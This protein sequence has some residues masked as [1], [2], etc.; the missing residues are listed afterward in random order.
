MPGTVVFE[1]TKQHLDLYMG[2]HADSAPKTRNERRAVIKMLLKWCVGQDYLPPAH[3]LFE[4]T[5]LA[6]ENAEPEEI[7]VY[8]ADEFS[9]LLIRASKQPRMAK[10]GEEAERD[11]RHLLPVLALGGLAGLR[12]KETLRLA[13]EDIFHKSGCIEVKAFKSKTR[14]R[15][16]IEICPALV[17]WLQP[18]RKS[19]G[20]IWQKSYDMLHLDFGDLRQELGIENRR[21]GLRHSFISAHFAK[22]SD[23]GY[24]GQQGGTSPSMIHKHYKGLMTKPEGE[25]WFAVAPV[26][27]TSIIM[28]ATAKRQ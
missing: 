5:E 16:L 13:W 28:L 24:T 12:F 2:G 21:N 4:A 19:T 7:E 14:S 20:P 9:A 27:P 3:R 15:R 8:T 17:G 11:Y 26:Q 6:S 1:I 18:Y 23:E 22:H 10:Q 25:A